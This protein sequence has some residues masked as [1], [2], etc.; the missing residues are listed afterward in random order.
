MSPPGEQPDIDEAC[1]L[2]APFSVKLSGLFDHFIT[3]WELKLL[4]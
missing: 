4:T 2:N 1:G 3:V